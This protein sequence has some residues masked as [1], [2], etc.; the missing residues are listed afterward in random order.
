MAAIVAHS[1][2]AQTSHMDS[3]FIL[4]FSLYLQF[5]FHNNNK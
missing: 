4:V 1:L 2:T 3:I 5:L